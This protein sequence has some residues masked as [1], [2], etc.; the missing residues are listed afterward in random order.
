MIYVRETIPSRR[1]IIFSTKAAGACSLFKAW[2]TLEAL[3]SSL[4]RGV[5]VTGILLTELSVL[6]WSATSGE[7][8]LDLL[9][10]SAIWLAK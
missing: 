7:S 4:K 3:D 1:R 10:S 9:A 6:S 8:E 5:D 2:S